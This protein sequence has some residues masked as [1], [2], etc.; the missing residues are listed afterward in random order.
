MQDDPGG[1]VVPMPTEG[2]D[3]RVALATAIHAAPGVYAVLAGSGMSTA[4]GIP[5]GW[6]VVQDLIRKIAIA[7][8]V[9]PDALGDEPE[10]WWESQG[11]AGPRYDTLLSALAS[12]GAGR[13]AILRPYFEAPTDESRGDQLPGG[14][15]TLAR[16]CAEGR[17]K[18]IVTTNFDRLIERALDRA[19]IPAQVVTGAEQ[20]AGMVPLAHAQMT[21]LKLNGDYASLGI[22]NTPEEL[23]SYPPPLH[24]LLQ[25]VIDEYGLLVIGWSA[26]YDLALAEAITG[27]ATRRYPTFWAA[28]NGHLSEE[29]RRLITVRQ[30]AVINTTGANELLADLAT[31]LGRLDEMATRRTRPSTLRLYA[32]QPNLSSPPS[33]WAMLPLLQLRVT[34]AIGPAP[35]QECGIIRPAERD[36]LVEALRAATV[37]TSLRVIATRTASGASAEPS[38]ETPNPAPL[39]DWIATAG[40]FQSTEDATYRLGGDA[41]AGVSALAQIRFPRYAQGNLVN[42]IL[43]I[44][45]S[46]S[47]PISLADAAVIWR[48]GLV[49]A[50]GALADALTGVLPAGASPGLVEIHVAAPRVDGLNRN[51]PNDLGQRIELSLLGQPTRSLS[52]AIGYAARISGPLS[53]DEAARLVVDGIEY[54][55]LAN[56]YVD[57]R[58][59]LE[60]L[61]ATLMIPPAT[62]TQV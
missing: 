36:A 9:D 13:Q 43:D 32:S 34:A 27:C 23:G 62:T 50:T 12:T 7:Q 41:A 46:L 25:R 5:T 52:D 33:G 51:R 19:G 22:R 56:G 2:I 37:T 39:S 28:H 10:A 38:D 42:A 60:S 48:D 30:A 57:P 6:K 21:V 58:I 49:L 15:D 35:L 14:H 11:H 40:S 31:R 24:E 18:V 1:L 55:A 26:D 20:I 53:S 54:M 8:G 45:L 59:A 17:F 4:S 61:R 29:A 3:P 47:D 44:A 16:L